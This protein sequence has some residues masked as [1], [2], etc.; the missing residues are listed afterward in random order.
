ML[1]ALDAQM[2]SA[3][4]FEDNYL[5]DFPDQRLKLGQCLIRIRYAQ[6]TAVLTYKGAPLAGGIFKSREEL[7]TC[8]ESGPVT[9]RI[10]EQLGLQIWFRYQKYRQE[11][12][13]DSV[14][15]AVDE[16]PVGNFAEFE[17]SEETIESLTNRMG[18]DSSR[19]L[20]FSYYS[21]Y[22]DHCRQEGK[23]PDHMIFETEA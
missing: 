22:L 21:L 17:G 1:S 14:Q 13:L 2:K 12:E 5:L 10:L 23:T 8:L 4:H 3:R 15:I 11:F 7:E 19:F 20:K 18:I 9:L 6:G 16:T